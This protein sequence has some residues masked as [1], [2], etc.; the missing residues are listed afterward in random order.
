MTDVLDLELYDPVILG[1]LMLTADLMIVANSTRRHMSRE[2]IDV[3]LGL[4]RVSRLP[5]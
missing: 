1:E 5:A 3:A 4:T 2:A